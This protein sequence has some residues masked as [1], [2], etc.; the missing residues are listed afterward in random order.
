[1][2][3]TISIMFS[4]F[5]SSYKPESV[6]QL[7]SWLCSCINAFDSDYFRKLFSRALVLVAGV[8]QHC[9]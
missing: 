7:K 4:V 5:N 1:M 6:E 2:F 3:S 9:L 8:I